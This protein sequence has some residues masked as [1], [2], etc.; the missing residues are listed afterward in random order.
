MPKIIINKEEVALFEDYEINAINDCL[1]KYER[2]YDT[3]GFIRFLST[4]KR[5]KCSVTGQYYKAPKSNVK[6]ITSWRN[7]EKN[8]DIYEIDL[9]IPDINSADFYHGLAPA[10]TAEV[11]KLLIQKGGFRNLSTLLHF[12]SKYKAYYNW[13]FPVEQNKAN[14]ADTGIEEYYIYT[15]LKMSSHFGYT[16]SITKNT[17]PVI[18]R[19]IKDNADEFIPDITYKWDA[20]GNLILI[21]GPT[22][23]ILKELE[24]LNFTKD[25]SITT[26]KNNSYSFKDFYAIQERQTFLSPTML[27]NASYYSGV[28]AKLMR[29]DAPS[30]P[31]DGNKHIRVMRL[32]V[33]RTTFS[34]LDAFDYG[35]FISHP[36]LNVKLEN[37]EDT[38]AT[39]LREIRKEEY[40]RMSILF[41]YDNSKEEGESHARTLLNLINRYLETSINSNTIAV[42]ANLTTRDECLI[43]AVRNSG[44]IDNGTCYC[45]ANGQTEF[46][47]NLVTFYRNSVYVDLPS[48]S[49]PKD[50]DYTLERLDFA[51]EIERET[52]A[53]LNTSHFSATWK[54]Y[55]ISVLGVVDNITGNGEGNTRL[56]FNILTEN[57][58]LDNFID[59]CEFR[60]DATE[61]FENSRLI[62]FKPIK[63]SSI[64]SMM[65][66]SLIDHC[67]FITNL[68]L[69]F[70]VLYERFT[71]GY[72]SNLTDFALAA[73]FV[74]LEM[75]YLVGSLLKYQKKKKRNKA[76]SI[77]VKDMM[78]K[79]ADKACSNVND[80][81]EVLSSTLIKS[82]IKLKKKMNSLTS[83]YKSDPH[84]I[85]LLMYMLNNLSLKDRN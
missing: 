79:R 80:K 78:L 23:Q 4:T 20:K 85:L 70:L 14:K 82:I 77:F 2:I 49:V 35:S 25:L 6:S 28:I 74:L 38:I 48:L 40:K 11:I 52:I 59:V 72:S 47:D 61:S 81:K 13:V 33:G 10:F 57:S 34:T 37:N 62:G 46:R 41:N 15:V 53:E 75:I 1:R 27:G 26:D 58:L 12:L 17:K 54:F 16:F 21:G 24:S 22:D 45:S 19:I 7:A 60:A 71:F 42:S 55:G 3:H 31:E 63:I 84:P 8:E 68:L 83:S 18:E 67:D 51:K 5:F 29:I 65:I 64:V 50:A 9:P 30:T 36:I 66:S 43:G 76:K 32:M 73:I 39:T 44:S 69:I 56:H